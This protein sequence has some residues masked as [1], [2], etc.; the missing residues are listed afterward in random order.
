[1]TANRTDSEPSTLVDVSKA[2]SAKC[3]VHGFGKSGEG[4]CSCP[5]RF[6]TVLQFEEPTLMWRGKDIEQYTKKQLIEIIRE[7]SNS[8]IR[9]HQTHLAD[10]E[11]LSSKG[12]IE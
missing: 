11:A 10:F 5:P 2:W 1:M 4:V 9:Q 7:I 3:N 12:G 6:S 8:H